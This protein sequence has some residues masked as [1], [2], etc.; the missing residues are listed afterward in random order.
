MGP[1]ILDRMGQLEP[2]DLVM[3]VLCVVGLHLF[4]LNVL[5]PKLLG[6]A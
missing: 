1:P 4:A 6:A 3:V 5:Y 2:G